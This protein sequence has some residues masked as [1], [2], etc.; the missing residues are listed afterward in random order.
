MCLPNSDYAIAIDSPS[1][2]MISAWQMHS[3]SINKLQLKNW[4]FVSNRF[5][6]RTWNHPMRWCK[7]QSFIDTHFE[8]RISNEWP[9]YLW[10]GWIADAAALSKRIWSTY[11][12]QS[13]KKR[14]KAKIH[15]AA[16]I[17]KNPPPK[18]GGP[19]IKYQLEEKCIFVG[20]Y[21]SWSIM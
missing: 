4:P 20:L 11:S 9:F 12:N 14:K 5:G 8:N 21:P 19:W 18:F 10:L 3:A 7:T 6:E 1:H 15:A 16:T 17:E 2:N 13:D